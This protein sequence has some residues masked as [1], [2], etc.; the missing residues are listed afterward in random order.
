MNRPLSPL[1]LGLIL[2]LVAIVV[3]WVPVRLSMPDAMWGTATVTDK[4]VTHSENVTY[5]NLTYAFTADDRLFGGRSEVREATYVHTNI[6]DPILVRYAGGDPS[7]NRYV[8]DTP[9]AVSEIVMAVIWIVTMPMLL[10]GWL[11][12]RAKRRRSKA[13][14][15]IA[16]LGTDR[17]DAGQARS[18]PTRPIATS[19]VGS[20]PPT[21]RCGERPRGA[22]RARLSCPGR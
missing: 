11:L 22:E 18:P 12:E 7:V 13:G 10:V 20:R 9:V 2:S 5:E 21:P 16:T 15:P 1:V 6:G 14:A 3:C 17:V 4:Y 19:S 8:A